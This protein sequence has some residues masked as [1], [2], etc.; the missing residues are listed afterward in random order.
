M[1]EFLHS[2]IYDHFVKMK[3][4][5]FIDRKTNS[6]PIGLSDRK[7]IPFHMV[8]CPKRVVQCAVPGCQVVIRLSEIVVHNRENTT[9]HLDLYEIDRQKKAWSLH[10]VRVFLL[11]VLIKQFTYNA[12][13]QYTL[14]RYCY[15]LSKM[16]TDPE[17][18]KLLIS[19]LLP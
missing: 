1:K 10:E 14:R 16:R 19:L 7:D 11:L 8:K 3:F 6:F 18:V 17:L 2:S 9:K 15:E 4:I 5:G 13:V 12:I